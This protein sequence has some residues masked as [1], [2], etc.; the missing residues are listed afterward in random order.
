[1]FLILRRAVWLSVESRRS[2][3]GPFGG[4]VPFP[5]TRAG[6]AKLKQRAWRRGCWFRDLKRKE[7]MLLDFTIRVVEKVRSFSLA[8]LVSGIVGKLCEVMESRVYRLVRSEGC[9]MAE[10]LSRIAQCWG[11]RAAKSWI[12]DRGFMQFLV[13][14]SLGELEG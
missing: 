3:E 11:Y 9:V 4:G 8:R 13:V 5:L 7:R 1:M 14:N 12:N 10:R 2:G 6:L